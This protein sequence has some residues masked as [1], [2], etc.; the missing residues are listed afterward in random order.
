V[1]LSGCFLNVDT[2]LF[3]LSLF[4]DQVSGDKNGISLEDLRL[5]F[6]ESFAL[7]NCF[8]IDFILILLLKGC[9][10]YLTPFSRLIFDTEI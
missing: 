10:N 9:T 8:G 4:F 2:G 3:L 6:G 1:G 7:I 5:G